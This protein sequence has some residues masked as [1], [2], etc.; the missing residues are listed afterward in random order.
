MSIAA[1]TTIDS[2]TFPALTGPAHS[3][4]ENCFKYLPSQVA[5]ILSPSEECDCGTTTAALT[6]QGSSTGC[7]LSNSF[8]GI[9][10]VP[11]GTVAVAAISSATPIIASAPRM[12]PRD[13]LQVFKRMKANIR[14]TATPTPTRAFEIMFKD[15]TVDQIQLDAWTVYSH[16]IG[17]ATKIDACNGGFWAASAGDTISFPTTLGPFTEST[18]SRC[19]YQGPSTAAGSV[20]CPGSPQ[21]TKCSAA[22]SSTQLCYNGAGYDAFTAQVEC[23]F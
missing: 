12:Y 8:F 7:A 1:F 19:M 6:I 15:G 16:Q 18:Y 3:N 17:Q 5:H 14:I 9:D 20:T 4:T 21:W 2:V 23:E 11:I 10:Q 13:L 22:T